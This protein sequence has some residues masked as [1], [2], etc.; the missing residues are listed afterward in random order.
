MYLRKTLLVPMDLCL[1]EVF[2]ELIQLAQWPPPFPFD[3]LVQGE[4]RGK[5]KLLLGEQEEDG[6][7]SSM[8]LNLATTVV[9]VAARNDRGGGGGAAQTVRVVEGWSSRND[10]FNFW[11]NLPDGC[12]VMVN[13]YYFLRENPKKLL[14]ARSQLPT[15]S[16]KGIYGYVHRLQYVC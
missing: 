15:T 9:W 8:V 7:P 14:P 10:G 13:C 3:V 1:R 4:A 2:Q 6:R 11:R 5:S 12:G 16:Q